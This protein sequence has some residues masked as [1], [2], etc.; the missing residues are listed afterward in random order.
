MALTI[1]NETRY[2]QRDLRK[3]IRRGLV[4]MGA[5]LDMTVSIEYCKRKRKRKG[6]RKRKPHIHGAAFI[7]GDRIWM[8][9]PRTSGQLAVGQFARVL[10]HEIFHC[11]GVDHKDMCESVRWCYYGKVPIWAEDT[12]I[13]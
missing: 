13:S 6:K 5:S 10:E 11:L 8:W 7:T 1:I 2:S 4:H 9:V 12:V 3:L